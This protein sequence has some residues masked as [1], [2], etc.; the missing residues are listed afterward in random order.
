MVSLLNNNIKLPGLLLHTC[1]A[2]CS[3]HIF[4]LLREKYDVAAFFYNPNIQP[5]EEY[6]LRREE[7]KKFCGR[8]GISFIEGEYN[9][10]NWSEAVCG[11]EH[12][13]EGGRRCEVCFKMRLE[14]TAQQA[15]ET[16]CAIFATTLTVSPHKNASLINQIGVEAGV[17]FGVMFLEAD[18]KKKEGFKKSAELSRQFGFYR[19]NYCGC[20]YSRFKI[21][22]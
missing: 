9:I 1:C 11:L 16:G 20:V 18:F 14:R 5:E 6:N 8:I 12:E 17:K 10:E 15:R 3:P 4:E 21:Q 7:L 13:P 2:P 22:D 19:Q